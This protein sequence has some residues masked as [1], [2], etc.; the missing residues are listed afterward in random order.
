MIAMVLSYLIMQRDF[1]I[2]ED[3]TFLDVWTQLIWMFRDDWHY[4]GQL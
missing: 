4:F 1:Y 3:S 2:S